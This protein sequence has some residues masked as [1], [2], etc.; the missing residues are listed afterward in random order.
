MGAQEIVEL[1]LK[2]TAADRLEIVERLAQSLDIPDPEIE[3]IWGQEAVRRLSA[4][5]AG[6]LQT[7][8]LEQALGDA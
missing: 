1:A 5:D 8:T 4:Y 3:R 7:V 2:L 6:R